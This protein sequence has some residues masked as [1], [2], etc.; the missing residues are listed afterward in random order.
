MPPRLMGKCES[1]IQEF[2]HGHFRVLISQYYYIF[3]L[4]IVHLK[5]QLI[6]NQVIKGVG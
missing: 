4:L 5:L 3:T 6:R 1:Q 2:F